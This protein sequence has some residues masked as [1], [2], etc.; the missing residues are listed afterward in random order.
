MTEQSRTDD[1][2]EQ[3]A[4]RA[5]TVLPEAIANGLRQRMDY[6]M[7]LHRRDPGLLDYDGQPS[8]R[9]EAERIAQAILALPAP[10]PAV[11]REALAAIAHGEPHL[12]GHDPIS[13]VPSP[14]QAIEDALDRL[15]AAGLVATSDGETQG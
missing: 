1:L 7:V 13:A 12:L 6:L 14:W 9:A 11:D 10:A 15:I 8:Y 4:E 5:P 2:L 3:A